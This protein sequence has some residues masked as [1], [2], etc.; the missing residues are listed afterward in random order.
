MVYKVPFL[1]DF[2]WMFVHDVYSCLLPSGGI[3]GYIWG[4]SNMASLMYP[5]CRWPTPPLNWPDPKTNPGTWGLP[6]TVTGPGQNRKRPGPAQPE[7]SGGP[8]SD[9][10]TT[11]A[12]RPTQCR[13]LLPTSGQRMLAAS[14]KNPVIVTM[15]CHQ[16]SIVQLINNGLFELLHRHIHRQNNKVSNC[17]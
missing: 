7:Q 10:E 17:I 2:F 5:Q 9:Q 12:Y 15:V 8:R 16:W 14:T 11:K 13:T 3:W 1:R 4:T 6:W